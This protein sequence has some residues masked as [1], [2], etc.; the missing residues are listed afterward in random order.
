MFVAQ[1]HIRVHRQEDV[2][3]SQ[4]SFS[5]HSLVR[6]LGWISA[7]GT[8]PAGLGPDRLRSLIFDDF[9]SGRL[10]GW[11]SASG[12]PPAGLGPDRLRSLIFDDFGSGR[13]LGWISVLGHL[14]R[15]S[16]QTVSDR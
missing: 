7:S 15:D 10:L 13:L 11:I 9:E 1:P 8:A 5:R 6:L 12:T 3:L 4:L 14:P 16:A 2:N